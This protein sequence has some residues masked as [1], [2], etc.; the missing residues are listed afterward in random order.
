[1][2]YPTEQPSGTNTTMQHAF[3]DVHSLILCQ[4]MPSARDAVLD[5]GCGTGGSSA[6][7]ADMIPP[8]QTAC[9]VYA[10]D[11]FDKQYAKD[12]AAAADEPATAAAL[13]AL[14][15]SMLEAFQHNVWER[16]RKIKCI[17]THAVY[18]IQ[19]LAYAGLYPQVVYIDGPRR[20][21]DLKELLMTV[22]EKM[23]IEY[24]RTGHGSRTHIAGGGWDIPGVAAAVREVASEMQLRVFVEQNTVWTFSGDCIKESR[25]EAASAMESLQTKEA[26]AA[27]AAASVQVQEEPHVWVAEVAKL[28]AAS[29]PLQE[30]EEAVRPRVFYKPPDG[31]AAQ[32][33]IDGVSLVDVGGRDKRRLTVLMHAAQADRAD[34]VQ[35]LLQRAGAGPN[36]AAE[37]SKYTALIV[38]VWKGL[39]DMTQLLL[40]A[41]ADPRARNRWGEDVLTVA[42]KG[43]KFD[44]LRLLEA[45]AASSSSR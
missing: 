20:Q 9:R 1:M 29:A 34:V 14:P 19:R 40:Q 33:P 8:T 31:G 36:T 32:P 22:I 2:D 26:A 37:D 38:A 7:L 43:R 39:D 4:L 12:L 30:I 3:T 5:L 42:R 21:E 11:F 23:A 28:I 41:G 35:F 27:A 6:T 17:C 45:A 18:A 16:R 24:A 13:S 25:N 15:C 10:V 44:C